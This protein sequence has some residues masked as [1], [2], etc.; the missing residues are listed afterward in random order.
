MHIARYIND[1]LYNHDC[2]IIPGLGGFVC[3]YRPAK[4]HPVQHQFYPPS[5]T[6]LF[7][8]ELQN[9]DG[10]LANRMVSQENISYQE[11]LKFIEAFVKEVM[12]ALNDGT[13]VRMEQIGIFHLDE[14]G[15][16]Q[17]EQDHR[18][19][20]L[21][22][23]YGLPGLVSPPV[24]RQRQTIYQP[25][26]PVFRDRKPQRT[27]RGSR[28]AVR[29]SLVVIPSALL[30]GLIAFNMSS[31]KQAVINETSL[32]PFFETRTEQPVIG[33]PAENKNVPVLSLD[34]PDVP[35]Q[36]VLKEGN[37]ENT[38]DFPGNIAPVSKTDTE[39]IKADPVADAKPEPVK[40]EV[41][42]AVKQYYLIAGSF[43]EVENAENLMS[44]Y[45]NKRLPPRK[46]RRLSRQAGSTGRT[47]Q[48][49]R[50]VQS[51]CM[52]PETITLYHFISKK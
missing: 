27:S 6:I 36:N 26:V 9:N 28:K 2:V 41:L 47:A 23:A 7:N 49:A 3:S 19:N 40:K 35:D 5:K 48:G 31:F 10:L 52:A 38:E 15:N 44:E 14:E 24:I 11:A 25:A 42:P 32:F 39:E 12:T 34:I 45:R 1:L 4:I 33:Q 20:H 37:S 22:N 43:A 16:I 21:K 51:Q 46:Y 8:R 30:V 17:F 29:W 13:R 18:V 50:S